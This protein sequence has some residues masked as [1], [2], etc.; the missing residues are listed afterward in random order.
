MLKPTEGTMMGSMSLWEDMFMTAATNLMRKNS[1][2]KVN[3]DN[4]SDLGDLDPNNIPSMSFDPS[5][6]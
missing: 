6:F 5:L 2:T 4:M 3:T 1:D